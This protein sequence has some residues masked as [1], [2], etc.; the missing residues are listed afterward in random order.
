M[1]K[2]RKFPLLISAA[3][4]SAAVL[5]ITLLICSGNSECIDITDK[6]SINLAFILREYDGCLAVYRGDAEKPYYVLDTKTEYLN[7]Y[8]RE[9]VRRGIAV[10][11]ETE[12]RRLIE[13]LTS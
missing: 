8:D 4:L 10:Y 7:E 5:I 12:L 1:M 2:L 3:A 9:Q 13:D 11:S 6:A